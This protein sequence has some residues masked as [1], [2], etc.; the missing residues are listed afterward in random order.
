MRLRL[1]VAADSSPVSPGPA[2]SRSPAPCL[3]RTSVGKIDKL[4]LRKERGRG[5]DGD[6][7]A[8]LLA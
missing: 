1:L 2:A 8:N 5:D 6:N 4:T 3:P 7:G